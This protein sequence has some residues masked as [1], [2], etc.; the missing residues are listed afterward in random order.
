MAM[1][2][3]ERMWCAENRFCKAVI[4]PSLPKDKFQATKLPPKLQ[5]PL[6]MAA[7][8]KVKFPILAVIVSSRRGQAVDLLHDGSGWQRLV[9]PATSNWRFRPRPASD[10]SPVS[11]RLPWPA[12]GIDRNRSVSLAFLKTVAAVDDHKLASDVAGPR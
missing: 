9:S 8:E 4:E 11:D 12:S 3:G 10:D 6:P 7:F 5:R 2:N 1:Q